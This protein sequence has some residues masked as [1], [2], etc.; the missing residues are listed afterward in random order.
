MNI[1][2][3]DPAILFPGISLLFLAYT[4]RYLT[5]AAVIRSLI[6]TEKPIDAANRQ[7]Q[8][9]NLYLRISLIKYTQ[10]LGVVAFLLCLASMLGLLYEWQS[11]GENLFV[12]SLVVMAASLVL[13]LAEI[14]RSGVSLHLELSRFESESN[15]SSRLR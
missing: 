13:A 9:A 12:L 3:T 1:S 10:A 14:L 15:K 5:I 7:A 4:N 2:I 11:I 6:N 8:I